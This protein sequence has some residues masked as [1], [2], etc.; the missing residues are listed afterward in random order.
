MIY[1]KLVAIA[2][3]PL[4]CL[5]CDRGTTIKSKSSES[6]TYEIWLSKKKKKKMM[7]AKSLQ[8]LNYTKGPESSFVGLKITARS[9]K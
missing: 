4:H 9:L 1:I 2:A 7:T 3:K 6:I 8:S 5:L